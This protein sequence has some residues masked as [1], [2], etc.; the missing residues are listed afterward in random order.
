LRS[1][2]IDSVRGDLRIPILALLLTPWVFSQDVPVVHET[3]AL[4]NVPCVV[5][6]GRGQT[7]NNLNINDFRLYVDGVQR[8]IDSLWLEGDLPLFL[9]VIE[10]VSQSQ[11]N[12]ISQNDLAAA[13][14]LQKVV[15]KQNRAF[16]VAVNDNV[17]LKAEVSE[18]PNGLRSKFPPPGGELLGVPCGATEGS[19]GRKR[20]ACGGT[21]LWDA[22]YAAAH[23]KLSGPGDNKALLILSSGNDTGSTHSFSSA[24]EEVKRSGTV[25]YAIQVP[26]GPRCECS[27][28]RTFPP[29]S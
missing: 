17:I 23:Y 15:H 9:G 12:R 7:I 4:V 6:D 11:Q 26:G 24:L 27:H 22:V 14:L 13:Q 1:D 18:G 8:Q 19:R 25:V 20:P 3:G 5:T 21:A 10:D 2:N 16:L 28:Q 29:G